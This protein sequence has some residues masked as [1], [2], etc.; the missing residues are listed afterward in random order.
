MAEAYRVLRPGGKLIFSTWNRV[1]TNEAIHEGRM[2]IES[3]F[4]DDPP[5]FYN[6]PFSMYN[7]KA[8]T[9][10]VSDAGFKDVKTTLVKKEGISGS[11]TDL[12]KGMVE[13]NPVYLSICDRDPSLINVIKD[14]IQKVIA[15][16]FGDKPVKSPLEAWMVEAIR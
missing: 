4:S 13:G 12:A 1:E 8:L 14:Q 3:Y 15:E 6:V 16:K 9:S 10:F 5:I 2:I 11:A 7:E